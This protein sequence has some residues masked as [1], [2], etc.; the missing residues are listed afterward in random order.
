MAKKNVGFVDEHIEKVVVGLC[1]LFFIGSL[2]V[3]FFSGRFTINENKPGKLAEAVGAAAESTASAI[4]RKQPEPKQAAGNTKPGATEDAVELLKQWFGDQA[5]GL[6]AIAGLKSPAGRTQPFPPSFVSTTEVAPEDRHHLAQMVA[7]GLPVVSTGQSIF[8]FPAQLPS[9]SEYTPGPVK[10]TLPATKRNWVAVAAQV[11]LIQQ[12]I[13]FKTEKYPDNS[14]PSIVKVH[15]ERFDQNEPWR[16]WQ[17]VNTT[18]PFKPIERPNIVN[19]IDDGMNL[20]GFSEFKELIDRSQEVIARPML[21]A[22]TGGGRLDYPA[23]PYFPDP[24]KSSGEDPAAR[25]KRWLQLAQKAKDGKTPFS[26]EDADAAAI[27]LRAVIGTA[28]AAG[29][30]V[31]KARSMLAAIVSSAKGQRKGILSDSTIRPP[32]KLMPILAYDLD[33]VPGHTYLYRTRYEV[34]NIFAGNV[35][36][37]LDPADARKLTIFSGWSPPSRP[38]TVESDTYFYLTRADDKKNEVTVTVFKRKGKETPRESTFKISIGDEIGGEKKTGA[39]KTDFSTGAV[40]IDIQF[41]RKLNDKNDVV[42]V[43]VDLSDGSVR[44]KYLSVDRNDKFRKSLTSDRTAG[45]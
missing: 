40:C 2:Y 18:L 24:P 16:G 21:N 42:M 27:L 28:G 32:E 33:V 25:A 30:D 38:V 31:D 10:D 4:M 34:I 19:R 37:L 20:E 5:R 8:E 14:Y 7:P 6:I 15:L 17:T 22:R 29:S 45:R 26:E 3:A 9:L 39:T 44:E 41:N 1:A 23:V 12:D 11:D 35:G 13:N 36:E 43:Y